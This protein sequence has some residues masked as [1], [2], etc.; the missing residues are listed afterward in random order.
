MSENQPII[1]GSTFRMAWLD[2]CAGSSF[3]GERIAMETYCEATSSTGSTRYASVSGQP[4]GGLNPS[5]A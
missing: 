1:S 3:F 4:S 2:A 5:H